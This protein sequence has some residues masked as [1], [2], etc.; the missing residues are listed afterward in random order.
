[1]HQRALESEKM[2]EN[3]S[4]KPIRHRIMYFIKHPKHVYIVYNFY[5]TYIYDII[6]AEE[7]PEKFNH[8]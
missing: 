2:Y 5:I 6:Q 4:K 8:V 1:M 3:V 7:T